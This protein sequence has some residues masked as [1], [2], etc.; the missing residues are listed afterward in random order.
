[1]KRSV[2]LLA[3]FVVGS[4]V[5]PLLGQAQSAQKPLAFDVASVKANT[6]G[7]VSVSMTPSLGGMT[8]TNYTLQFLLRVAYRIQDFQIINGPE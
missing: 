4:S 3:A 6:S 1:M 2:L 8:I 5:M 7:D